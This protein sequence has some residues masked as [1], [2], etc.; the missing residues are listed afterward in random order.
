M[1][2]RNEACGELLMDM[3]ELRQVADHA[4]NPARLLG[5]LTSAV[6]ATEPIDE[7]EIPEAH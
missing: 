3:W 6:C 5:G 4:G 1:S 2:R 7:C